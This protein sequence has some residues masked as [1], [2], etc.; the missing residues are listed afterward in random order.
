MTAMKRGGSQDESIGGWSPRRMEEAES[1][2]HEHRLADLASSGQ[3]GLRAVRLALG[4]ARHTFRD[5]FGDL[6][7]L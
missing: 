5:G 4:D 3:F 2:P 1:K 6:A 7:E